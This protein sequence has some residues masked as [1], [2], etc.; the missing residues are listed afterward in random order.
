VRSRVVGLTAAVLL[1][2][3]AAGAQ[4]A[5]D[6]PP[7]EDRF[8]NAPLPDIVLT[9][10]TGERRS[11]S[12]VSRG[13]PLLLTFVFTRCAGVCSPF[14]ASWRTAD[15]SVAASRPLQRLVL[16]F[17]RRDTPADMA[18][19]AHHLGIQAN[20]G[21]TFAVASAADVQRL[22]DATG[23][24]YDWDASRSQFDHPAMIAAARD[25]RLVRLLVGGTVTPRRLDDLIRE[26]RG[27]FVASYPLPGRV[28]F[29]CVQ[30]DEATGQVRLDWGV[31]LL[32]VPVV[33]CTLVTSALF[34]A[35]RSR[36]GAAPSAAGRPL[37]AEVE[38][39]PQRCAEHVAGECR[40]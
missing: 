8:L 29:R 26:A 22:A 23:F 4:P 24:W 36:R 31:L 35:G 25:G 16:S 2:A 17:D 11:V 5:R 6:A 39:G 33:A 15:R 18:A 32:L 20:R 7:L 9:T 21:W 28:R 12:A 19:L 38:E 1:L 30:F 37:D 27:E 40:G 10:S 13:Q 34:R 3:G 14:L